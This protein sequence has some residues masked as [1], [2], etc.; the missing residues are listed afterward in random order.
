ML[1]GFTITSSILCVL[2]MLSVDIGR[3]AP[4]LTLD[5][6][7]NL[8]CMY[9]QFAFAKKHYMKCCG[10][11]D[12][13]CRNFGLKRTQKIFDKNSNE[14]IIKATNDESANVRIESVEENV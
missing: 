13:R 3:R 14:L 2:L 12:E 10:W 1:F 9:L 7:V 5:F 11:C 6:C 8:W 4:F